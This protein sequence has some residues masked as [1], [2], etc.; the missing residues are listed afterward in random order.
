[1]EQLLALV[2]A[3]ARV[4]GVGVGHSWNKDFFCAGNT[5]DAIDIVLTEFTS[6]RIM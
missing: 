4:K 6:T 5:S 3:F 2:K 1:V